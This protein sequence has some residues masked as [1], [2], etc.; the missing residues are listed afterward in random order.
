[1]VLASHSASAQGFYSVF[2]RDGMDVWAVG[3]LGTYYRSFDGGSRWT[4]GLLG[5]KTLRGVAA[6]GFNAVVVGDSG[7]IF[8]SVD[9]GGAWALTVVPGVPILRAVQMPADQVAYAV[10]NGG[11]ILK[12]EDGGA[13]WALQ[14]TGT[15]STLHAVRFRDALNGWAVGAAGT[16]L[17]TNDGG[18]N[19]TPV[20]VPTTATLLGVDFLGPMVWVVGPEATAL[21]SLDG[22]ISWSAIDLGIDTRSDVNAVWIDS[23]DKV[24]L[25]GGGG[26]MRVTADSGASWGFLV[27]PLMVPIDGMAFA[28]GATRGWACS[29]LTRAIVTNLD[30]TLW[31]FPPNSTTTGSWVKKYDTIFT[32]RGST[33][34]VNGRNR[35]TVYGAL[36]PFVHRSGDRGETWSVIGTI[37]DGGYLP[38]RTNAFYVSP[39]DSNLMIAACQGPPDRVLRSTDGGIGWTTTLERSFSEYGP[40]LEMNPDHPDTLLFAPEDG[41]LYRSLNFGA[42]WDSLSHPGFRSPC[43]VLV[44]PE[45]NDNVWVGDGVTGS[46]QGE[47]WR[48]T[49]GGLT[50]ALRYPDPANPPW[51]G[52]EVPM[53][54]CPRLNNRVGFA[55]HWPT[56]GMSRTLD[57]GQT[58]K[59]MTNTPS[60]WGTDFAKDDPTV[61]AFGVYSGGTGFITTDGGQNFFA[62]PLPN[63]N[64]SM[65]AYDRGTIFAQQSD[66]IYKFVPAYTMPVANFQLLTVVTPN[67]GEIWNSGTVHSIT[68]TSVSLAIARIEYRSAPGAPW[69]LV[70]DVPGYLGSYAWA[71]PYDPS[72]TAKVRIHDPW[73]GF[74]T[75]SSNAIFTIAAPVVQE[76]P[77]A[78]SY[79][80]HPLGSTTLDTLRLTNAGTGPLVVSA[81]T[82]LGT[83][84]TPGRASLTL[85]PGES[86]TIGVTFRPTL[87]I[88]YGDVLSLTVNTPAGQ[89]AVPLNGA[90]T[91]T[92]MLALASPKGG[93][94]WQYNTTRWIQWRSA[95]VN[96]VSLDYQT[97]PGPWI[98]IADSVP[99]AL[100]HYGWTLPY[101]PT[102]EAR[103][104]IRERGG[105]A[106][107]SSAAPFSITT[108]L[109][110]VSRTR[111]D[112]GPTAAAT[113]TSDTLQILNPGTAPIL[114]SWIASDHPEFWPS[115][116]W[117]T[118]PAGGT[119]S[120]TVNY[121][122][123][124]AGRDTATLSFASNDPFTPH[125]V[126]VIGEGTAPIAAG[127][128]RPVAFALAQNQP[129]PFRDGTVIQYALPQR[130]SVTLEV[131]D[132][133]G[134][135]VA[136]L[137][138]AEQ[139]AGQYRA[140][141]GP[142]IR[143]AGGRD[144]GVRPAGVY[145]YRLRAGSFV[146][147]HKMLLL[148]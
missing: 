73:D 98:V 29:H 12:S 31:D 122:P 7:K 46:G 10:G 41:T 84:F 71:V 59:Q 51:G 20:P 4:I 113:M 126:Q 118:L 16:V 112:L 105:A 115:R 107:D 141:F 109:F 83:A 22:G 80:A 52:N 93:E 67:G 40:P 123:A 13:T 19:W 119:D 47:I 136:T 128:A 49:D 48:S 139:E 42:T 147:T 146:A 66:G 79:G 54:A 75:D 44:V 138:R 56:G 43:D 35:N 3:D 114:V 76:T 30:G 81:V 140:E 95:L 127:P 45:D 111:I 25:G 11:R 103:V 64:Y 94:D 101:A 18:A 86:D 9:S 38:N 124:T 2:S 91:D 116:T 28:A 97:A 14:Y 77:A 27:H 15:S 60:A 74:P 61:A 135:R 57:G 145:F 63:S 87:A 72:A 33:L 104:R 121:L 137:V 53:M 90:G 34:V 131:F 1:M 130:A 70:A 8:H 21:R 37:S 102:T 133:Q 99:A 58:W 36:G 96:T 129:N 6:H 65:L 125:T 88:E 148:P 26:F 143:A 89:I 82:T 100:G 142:G 69:Q 55:S 78:L 50:F 23:P 24:L 120:V 85:A 17:T 106:A 68:W 117:L 132:L 92:L 110:A 144:P 134:H 62:N 32:V 108:P 39:R 5:N